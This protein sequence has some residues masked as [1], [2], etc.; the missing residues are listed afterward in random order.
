MNTMKPLPPMNNMNTN[1]SFIL[2][3]LVLQSCAT[4]GSSSPPSLDSGAV[5]SRC[6]LN[7]DNG[8][9]IAMRFIPKGNFRMGSPDRLRWPS[10]TAHS[11]QLTQDYWMAET[12][13]TQS[14]WKAVMGTTANEMIAAH[15]VP[16]KRQLGFIQ[17]A[18]YP[19]CFVTPD[20]ALRF[21]A[22]LNRKVPIQNGWRWALPTEAQ[23]E[24]ACRAGTSTN[25]SFGDFGG[26]GRYNCFDWNPWGDE[27]RAIAIA[28][29]RMCKVSRFPANDYGLYD[30]HGNVYEIC[31]DFYAPYPTGGSVDPKGPAGGKIRVARGGS[32]AVTSNWCDSSHRGQIPTGHCDS[33]TGLRVAIVNGK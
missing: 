6:V 16:E 4:S 5:G 33:F 10:E 31:F 8:S 26:A 17:G 7:L 21:V 11:V 19:M 22:E 1:I 27:S 18:N 9:N 32:F 15:N 23:W 24:L 14:Q 3:C 2:A 30:M 28:K 13:L 12:E 29:T 20:D 25:Y